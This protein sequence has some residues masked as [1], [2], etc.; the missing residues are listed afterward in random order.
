M[1]MAAAPAGAAGPSMKFKLTHDDCQKTH[2]SRR[3]GEQPGLPPLRDYPDQQ[4]P[5]NAAFHTGL[6]TRLARRGG[7][8]SP[9][10][11]IAAAAIGG[12]IHSGAV[13]H[14]AFLVGGR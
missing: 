8:P 5:F 11:V 9:G 4:V 2:A 14:Q 7:L 12:L 1:M 10:G 13:A 6:V 3:R